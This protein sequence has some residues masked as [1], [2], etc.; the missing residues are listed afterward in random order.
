ML[1]HT[2]VELTPSGLTPFLG[3]TR[4]NLAVTATPLLGSFLPSRRSV[5]TPFVSHYR[6][7]PQLEEGFS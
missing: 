1:F 4:G 5:H 2:Q 6:M 3:L 7:E